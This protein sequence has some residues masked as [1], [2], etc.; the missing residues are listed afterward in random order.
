MQLRHKIGLAILVL[1]FGG[2]MLAVLGAL[3][4]EALVHGDIGAVV[5][6]AAVVLTVL[7]LWLSDDYWS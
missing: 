7:G 6:L 3:V 2:L 4:Y 5:V 1:V